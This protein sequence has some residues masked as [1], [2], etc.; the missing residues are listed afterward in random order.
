LPYVRPFNGL[1]GVIESEL[2]Q[3]VSVSDF[4]CVDK[5]EDMAKRLK[6]VAHA[7]SSLRIE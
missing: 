3:K 6:V 4:K 7:I 2:F 5:R 1:L